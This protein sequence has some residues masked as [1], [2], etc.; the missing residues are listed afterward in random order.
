MK[1]SFTKTQLSILTALGLIGAASFVIP[2]INHSYKLILPIIATISIYLFA[3]YI[4]Y[5]KNKKFV[6]KDSKIFLLYNRKTK[7]IFNIV[8]F[9]FLIAVVIIT[10]IYKYSFVGL[11]I[12]SGALLYILLS[13]VLF[14]YSNGYFILINNT[15]I[16]S[17]ETGFINLNQVKSHTLKPDSMVLEIKLKNNETKSIEYNKFINIELFKKELKRKFKS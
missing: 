13:M 12:T 3:L 6:G 9:I 7:N 8:F 2:A 5:L 16:Y 4:K 15:A 10:L 14:P 17:Y 1:K 11:F